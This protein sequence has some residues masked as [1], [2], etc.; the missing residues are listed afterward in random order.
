MGSTRPQAEC[1][2]R[3]YDDRVCGDRVY[4]TVPHAP[5]STMTGLTHEFEEKSS[6]SLPLVTRGP[7][8]VLLCEL[9]TRSFSQT[10]FSNDD[11]LSVRLS[12][13]QIESCKCAEFQM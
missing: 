12:V 10:F 8:N 13:R 4:S 5:S 6:N 9:F 3:V 11:L 1:S 7:F 2:Y